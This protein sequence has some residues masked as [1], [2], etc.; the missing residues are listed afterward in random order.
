M[1]VNDEYLLL[2]RPWSFTVQRFVL[3]LLRFISWIRQ[4]QSLD[5]FP[6]NDML[7][8]DFNNVFFFHMA[9]PDAFGINHNVRP[10]LADVETSSFICPHFCLQSALVKLALKQVPNLFAPL[11]SARPF[12]V[13]ISPSVRANENMSNVTQF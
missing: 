12:R 5:D 10:V 9:I 3:H 7:F 1:Q 6:A 2:D 8:Y 11:L 4:K 13:V